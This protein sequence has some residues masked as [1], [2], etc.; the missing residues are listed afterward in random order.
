MAR[1]RRMARR[2]PPIQ[3][4]YRVSSSHWAKCAVDAAPCHCEERS[5]AAIPGKRRTLGGLPR[6]AC[7]FFESCVRISY[8]SAKK[9]RPIDRPC[10]KIPKVFT[11]DNNRIREEAHAK[12]R[13]KNYRPVATLLAMTARTGV[14]CTFDQNEN[15]WSQPRMVAAV[16]H[17][18]RKGCRR[19]PDG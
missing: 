16:G 3:R 8:C 9:N 1:H 14:N 5:D 11:L 7:N 4:P 2:R 19:Y 18:A 10:R 13:G 6:R 15:C 17:A 12:G